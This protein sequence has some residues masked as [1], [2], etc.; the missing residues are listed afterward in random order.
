[1]KEFNYLHQLAPTP[2]TPIA[3]NRL[4]PLGPAERE[5]YRNMFANTGAQ[6]GLL[7][8][9]QAR[10]IFLRAR[11]PNETLG[12]IWYIIPLICCVD[13]VFRSLADIH[14]RGALDITEFTIAMHLIQSFMSN[15]ITTVPATLPPELFT[16]A[17]VAP[18]AMGGMRR[19]D[20]V[21]ST[22]S[23]RFLLKFLLKFNKVLFVRISR[24]A[25][26]PVIDGWDVTP[27]DKQTFDNLFKGIDT[28]NKGFIDGITLFDHF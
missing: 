11:L 22:G 15:L 23:N 18:P 24:K 19:T 13:Y 17:S 27:Q 10:T 20:S 7:D 1:M 3:S 21:S 25:V 14:N 16:A 5:R 9:E 26:N 4:P 12:Q 6:N 2:S 28:T 8:G